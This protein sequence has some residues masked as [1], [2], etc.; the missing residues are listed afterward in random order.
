MIWTVFR[1]GLSRLRRNRVELVLTFV[2]PICF[3]SIFALIFGEGLGSSS[4]SKIKAVVVDRVGD[5]ASAAA[6]ERIESMDSLR[7]LDPA[8]AGKPLSEQQAR[9]LVRRGMVTLAVVIRRE[10]DAPN[11]E[12]SGT[13]RINR[14][15][16]QGTTPRTAAAARP[17]GL[18]AD[19]LIDASDQVAGQMATA[20]VSQALL[21]AS[22]PQRRLMRRPVL[23]E[24]ENQQSGRRPRDLPPSL[25]DGGVEE[26]KAAP[27][28]PEVEIVDVLSADKANPVVSMYA[29]GIAVMF[30]LFGA[31]SGGGSLLEER[32]NTTLERLLTTRLS[33]DHLLLGKW[34]YQTVLGIVQV[35]VMFLWGW[36]VFE[37][38][39]W[40]NLDGFL[41]MTCVTAGA[42]ASFG[43][44]MATACRTRGQLNGV[45]VVL[46]LTMSALG[47]S[48]VPRYLMSEQLRQ[49]GL[50]STF[51]A[52]ALDGY[53]K[54]FWRELPVSELW[55]QVCVLM[56]A[57]AGMLVL[58][59]LLAIRWETS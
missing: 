54:V 21:Q 34:T 59:R 52:W 44:L 24:S 10:P 51:N 43:L 19:L 30:L 2:V 55:P 46:I 49:W 23:S 20:L 5:A 15:F 53:D 4:T 3:F 22:L 35:S 18:A 14:D 13:N 47:G 56:L 48:M 58:A 33:M 16:P 26:P 28:Q 9:D 27:P 17:A 38:D 8:P 32:E 1:I 41:L 36:W 57:S 29:A 31:S 7:L 12:T 37:V 39:L 25:V 45:S 42:A 11:G 50:Y 40:R 6:V